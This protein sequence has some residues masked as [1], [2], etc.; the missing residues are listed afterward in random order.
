MS[1]VVTKGC[2]IQLLFHR[3][4]IILEDEYDL[5]DYEKTIHILEEAR[6]QGYKIGK[7]KVN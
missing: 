4:G 5:D 6:I 2:S 1:D 7:S 3:F